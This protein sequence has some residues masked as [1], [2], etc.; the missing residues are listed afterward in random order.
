[1]NN[2]FK[3]VIFDRYP[4]FGSGIKYILEKE[5]NLFILKI[6][7]DNKDLFNQIR[8]E[9][10]HLLVVDAIHCSDGC[11]P[12]LRNIKITNPVLKVFVIH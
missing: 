4:V 6:I 11:I 7:H 5:S 3:I 8:K 12:L 1:M 10:P 2:T 9:L